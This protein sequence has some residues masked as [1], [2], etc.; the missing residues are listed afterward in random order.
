MIAAYTYRA[1]LY[2]EACVVKLVAGDPGFWTMNVEAALDDFAA[3]EKIDRYDER[4]FDSG[5]FPKVVFG[6][7]LEE[8]EYCASCEREL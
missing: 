7:W 1:D 5:D 3:A 2:C 6:T 4:T 8:D